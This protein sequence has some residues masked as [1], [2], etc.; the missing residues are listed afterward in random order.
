MN[1]QTTPDVTDDERRLAR[2]WAESIEST[3]NSAESTT[4]PW[5]D[6]AIAAAR[7]ILD[8]V[9]T[10]PPPTLADITEEERA[11]CKWMQADVKNHRERYVIA[12]P[13]DNDGEVALIDSDGGIDW[14]FPEYVTPRPDLPRMEWPGDTPSPALP[15]GWRLA[16][17][18]KH[19][20]VLVTNTTPNR[21]GNVYFVAPTADYIMGYDCRS[22]DPEELTYLE[23]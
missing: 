11:A 16:E 17:H 21:L 5:S 14:I 22:C 1:D 9:P 18:E 19:G 2:K 15:D 10:P 3:T 13:D 7:V 20:L 4:N 23:Q 6:R 8:T 12:T